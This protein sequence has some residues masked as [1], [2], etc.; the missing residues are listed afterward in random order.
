MGKKENYLDYVPVCAPDREWKLDEK[1]LVEILVRNTGFY[2]RLAQKF[3]HRPKESRISLDE[4]GSFI[5]QQMDGTRTIY[6]ISVLVKEKYGE[7]AEPLLPRL[8][9][10]FKI[11]YANH[12]IGYSRPRVQKKK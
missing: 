3:F 1:G 4:Y 12:F 2:N 9:K 10:F 7:K 6:D 11:L 8:T 5:W